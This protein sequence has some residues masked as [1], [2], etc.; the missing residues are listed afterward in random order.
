[1]GLNALAGVRV[2]DL[3]HVI[4]GPTA[5]HYL[6]LEG[7]EVIKIEKPGK[8]D[9]LRHS[10]QA[11][12]AG[13][14]VGF[15]SINLGKKS[16]ALDLKTPGGK[17]VMRRLIETA[18]VF[19]ENFRPGA[20]VR[21]GF[22]HES[23]RRL[24]PQIIYASISG[25]GQEGA[26]RSRAA[27][28]HVVQSAIGM[29]W[30]QG[31][32]GQEPMKVGFPVI[33]TATGMMG[34]QAITAALVRQFRQQQGAYLD[35]SMAQAGLQLMWPDASRAAYGAGDAPRIGNRGFSGSPGAATFECVDGWLSTAANTMP[36]F[37]ALCE[38][39]GLPE[40]PRDSA[41]IDQEALQRGGFLVA[42]DPN[43]IHA[44]LAQ[45]MRQAAVDALERTLMASQ[46]PCAKIRPLSE[47]VAACQRE[48]LMTLPLRRTSY[49]LGQMTDF[50]PGYKAD[51]SPEPD[52]A[53]APRLGQHSREILAGLGMTEAEVASLMAS[54]AV[55]A[56]D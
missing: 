43:R 45:A 4:A 15:A 50:G 5:S 6:A 19:I 7:A 36:Q 33:D 26:W 28:D 48:P 56:A 13:I 9:I 18:D 32:E 51:Q 39:L 1:M 47:L 55:A 35:I 14:S 29:S 31:L 20:V 37:T 10:G 27:Y 46:V 54:G 12:A 30:M 3:S 49:P 8:G 52:L 38:V 34:A 44:L 40:L 42:K 2:L 17:D 53:A 24:R 22:D 11:L 21:L 25:F 23:V 16:L 41:L